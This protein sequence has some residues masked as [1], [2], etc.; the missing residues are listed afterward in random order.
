VSAN[1][2]ALV[3]L[4]AEAALMLAIVLGRRRGLRYRDA[5][6][7]ASAAIVIALALATAWPPGPAW[8]LF[9]GLVAYVASFFWRV[10][11]P[12]LHHRQAWALARSRDHP[13]DPDKGHTSAL[14][15]ATVSVPLIAPSPPTVAFAAFALAVLR[16]DG[17]LRFRSAQLTGAW[18]AA[19]A[20]AALLFATAAGDVAWVEQATVEPLGQLV[21]I[22]LAL[23]LAPLSLALLSAQLLAGWLGLRGQTVLPWR[24]V[25]AALSATVVSIAISVVLASR[26]NLAAV[27]LQLAEVAAALVLVASLGAAAIVQQRIQPD[28][29]VRTLVNR[30]TSDW[31][32]AVVREVDV[33]WGR[34]RRAADP[35]LSIESFLRSAA[36]REGANYDFRLAVEHVVGR[37]HELT[38]RM[39][40]RWPA[41]TAP[42]AASIELALDHY[43]ATE[44]R[45]LIE[46]LARHK[47]HWA[48]D[49]LRD[50]RHFLEP[51]VRAD[52]KPPALL[53][54]GYA[55]RPGGYGFYSSIVRAALENRLPDEAQSGI[56]S[57]MRYVERVIAH[58][59][60][61]VGLDLDYTE[62]YPGPTPSEAAR[63]TE[64][65]L[66]A[67]TW[68][69]RD[70][71]RQSA[72]DIEVLHALARAAASLI[73]G[74]CALTDVRWAFWI[75]QDAS[76]VAAEIA[77]V[78]AGS[79]VLALE[80]PARYIT[81]DRANPVHQ[82]VVPYL[83]THHARV[84]EQVA[85]IVE[86]KTVVDSAMLALD[87]GPAFVEEA[88]GIA[89]SLDR[90]AELQASMP[91]DENRAQASAQIP[92]RIAQIREHMG[93]E[94][95]RFDEVF[96]AARGHSP[97][98]PTGE[99][100]GARAGGRPRGGSRASRR[101][102]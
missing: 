86:W 75:V 60:D 72:G 9:T 17:A 70:W 84:L 68:R 31:L 99:G 42:D 91:P 14:V 51:D 52:D 95:N 87:W 90:V 64:S 24:W 59:P 45:A 83:A 79:R 98:D 56:Y 88:A 7:M 15:V 32:T 93:A 74:A 43:L 65:A 63:E 94:R 4:A 34:V 1:A 62:A 5:R 22:Q 82:R 40:E 2:S 16:L 11:D 55:V 37:I 50:L 69:L 66:Q 58:L 18:L 13:R 77:R 97:V 20:L 46:E 89:V 8:L 54:G 36:M 61:P 44:L 21:A 101:R 30:L 73:D 38:P 39:V 28:Y 49:D 47:V 76:L 78:G 3:L 67:H 6:L 102:R 41:G 85:Q 53:R 12:A 100:R 10:L 57:V 48:L 23:G 80:T 96:S 25:F 35:F 81:W 33:N 29:V 27:E 19:I 26:R 92:G 71:A